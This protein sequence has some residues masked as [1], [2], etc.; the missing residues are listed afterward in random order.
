MTPRGEVA[1]EELYPEDPRTP[2]APTFGD[3]LNT[4]V[5]TANVVDASSI[6][7]INGNGNNFTNEKLDDKETLKTIVASDT[8]PLT[9]LKPEE[10]K[11]VND[12]S[13]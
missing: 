6:P 1:D 4:V 11:I 12:H 3:K 9:S 2:I 5:P 10:L 7:T 13:W 8:K